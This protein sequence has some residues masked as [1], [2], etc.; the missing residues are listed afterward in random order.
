MSGGGLTVRSLEARLVRVRMQRPLGTSAARVTEAPLVLLD[1]HTAEGVTGRSYLFCYLDAVGHAVV[2]LAD[3]MNDLLAGT[4]ADP[5]ALRRT[6]AA[7]TRL[8]GATGPIASVLAGLDVAAWDALAVAAG[9]PLVRLLGAAPRPVPAYNS[10]G[11]GLLAP[12]AVATQ[13]V[14]LVEEGFTAV[15]VRLGRTRAADDLAAVRAVRGAV[16]P[17]IAV[18][19][20]F[21][22]ALSLTEARSRCHLL[23]DEGLAW[24]EEPIR[25]DDYTGTAE[26]AAALRTPVQ[27]GENFAGPR[28][29]AAATAARAADLVMPDLD[30]IGGVTGWLAAAAIADA[31]GVPMS[32]HLYPEVSA[33]LLA[34]TPTAHWLEYV[35]WAT[36]VLAEPPPVV[37]GAVR[38][39]EE[40]GSGLRWD[41]EAVAH[42]RVG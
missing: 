29:L 18:M 22:Q 34:A 38:V 8:V 4:A 3:G 30:R 20:D 36:P 37:D 27:I 23:D 14:E 17:E 21:N 13:A 24:I 6:L 42:Y 2:V 15:K 31:A 33:H 32:S 7:H 9:L 25:H 1:L 19:A 10:N 35:D 41:E 40:A 5:A 26:L 12:A 39:P 28:S 11:L 16:G